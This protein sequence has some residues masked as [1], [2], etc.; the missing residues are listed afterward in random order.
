[1]IAVVLITTV[2]PVSVV[3]LVKAVPVPPITPEKVVAPVELTSNVKAQLT[4]Q[5][6]VIAP[7]PA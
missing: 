3:K 2:P 7:L 1:M 6:K 4:V 5:P